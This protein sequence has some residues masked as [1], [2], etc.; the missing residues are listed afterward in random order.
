TLAVSLMVAVVSA[1]L[2]PKGLR[3][4]RNWATKVKADFVINVIQPGRFTPI[5]R[6][7][8]LHIRER[9]PDGQLLGIFIDDRRDPK[10]RVTSISDYGEI[11]E[12]GTGTFLVLITGSVQRLEAG[13]PDPTIVRFERYAFDLSRFT[14]GPIVQ[15]LGVRERNLWDLISPDPNDSVFKQVPTHFRAELHDRLIAPIY[16]FAFTVICFAILGA[17]RTSRQSREMSMVLALSATAVLRLIGFACNVVATQSIVAVYVLYASVFAALA[18][19]LFAI[20][21]GVVLEPPAF[22]TQP[23][24]LLGQFRERLTQR[25]AAT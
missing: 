17:P 9:R 16:P 11:V 8:V 19:G 13:R 4:L 14:G 6:G 3:E 22:I 10:E 5:E 2:A 23:I 1:Y 25:L 18:L 24:T 20:A 21:R 12:S 15:T 7:L